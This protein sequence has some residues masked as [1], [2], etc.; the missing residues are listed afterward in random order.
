[1][2]AG[3]TAM[4][5]HNGDHAILT[6]DLVH[7][8]ADG[9]EDLSALVAP[10]TPE[11]RRRTGRR[12]WSILVM[13]GIGAVGAAAV[14]TWPRLHVPAALAEATQKIDQARRSVSVVSPTPSKA[15]AEVRL[16]GSTS[17]LQETIIYARTSG[18][19]SSLTAD[20]GDR[21]KAGQLLATIASPEVDQQLNE[22]R[23][24]RE[25]G[26]TNL[27]LAQSRLKRLKSV[28]A[29]GAVS[30]QQLD[31][32]QALYNSQLAAQRVSD[33]VV[34]RL[35]TDQSYQ[36]VIAPFDGVITRRNIELGSL[37][38]AGSGTSVSSLFEL[39]QQNTMRIFVDVPQSWAPSI[40]VGM[41]ASVELREFPDEQFQAKVVRT[42]SA[43]DPATRTLRTELHIPNPQGR[44]IPGMYVQVRFSC[45]NSH[46]AI[47]VPSNTLVID[48][49]GVNVVR[50]DSQGR[51]VRTPV[52]IGRDFGREVEVVSG[53]WPDARLVVSPRD[54]LA[55]GET[56]T[57]VQP[58]M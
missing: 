52:R 27:V 58:R 32:A 29:S 18:Y 20:I 28:S 50:V 2:F 48:S 6:D 44:L 34:S 19:I 7:R 45:D 13:V 1:M 31:D 56:V 55:D 54:D 41:T 21:V 47:V 25:E 16:P 39:T 3:N 49:N 42:S 8:S 38:T 35:E 57:V 26:H 5:K 43:L 12:A 33:D 23:A 37:I 14:S 4:R 53:L 9:H 40:T 36:K 24:R 10:S 51:I 30:A 11:V 15:V 22:A 17:A 46:G